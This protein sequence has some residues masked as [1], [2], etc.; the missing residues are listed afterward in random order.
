MFIQTDIPF[1][2]FSS[3]YISEAKKMCSI[4]FTLTI[5]NMSSFVKTQKNQLHYNRGDGE[6]VDKKYLLCFCCSYCFMTIQHNATDKAS[7]KI[8]LCA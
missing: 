8:Q 4:F 2:C 6:S 3:R 7:L 5:R 1:N